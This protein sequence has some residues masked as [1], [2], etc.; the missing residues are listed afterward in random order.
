MSIFAD[1]RC[2]SRRSFWIFGGVFV[3]DPRLV[4]LEARPCFS[5][6]L[7]DHDQV[8][9]VGRLDRVGDLPRLEGERRL[10]ELLDDA[11]VASK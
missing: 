3:E 1:L 4:L 5:W 8:V 2:V 10:A 11:A 7:G 9:A 6:R